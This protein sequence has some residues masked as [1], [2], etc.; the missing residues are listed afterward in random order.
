MVAVGHLCAE[1][2]PG[3]GKSPEISRKVSCQLNWTELRVA[4]EPQEKGTYS[5]CSPQLT[6]TMDT[7][8]RA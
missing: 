5:A 4:L 1:E 2:P 7:F 6:C 8:G 3:P